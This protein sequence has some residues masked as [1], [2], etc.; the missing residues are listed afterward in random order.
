M[1]TWICAFVFLTVSDVRLQYLREVGTLDSERIVLHTTW[2]SEKIRTFLDLLHASGLL[3][4]SYN[5]IRESI[6][7]KN[8]K[9]YRADPHYGTLTGGDDG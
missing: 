7:K 4:L 3:L 8:D 6:L 5:G 9:D 2:W 1:G